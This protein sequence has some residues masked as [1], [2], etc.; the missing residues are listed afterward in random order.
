[1]IKEACVETYEE[2]LSA[3]KNGADQLEVCSHMELDGLTPDKNLIKKLIS[4]SDIPI[5]VMIR[6]RGGSFI[7][8]KHEISEMVKTIKWFK[9]LPISGFVFG[10]LKLDA[11]GNSII[12][13][14]AL[15]K[16]CNT[17]APFPVTFHKAIDLCA[18]ITEEAEK[19]KVF[20]NIRFILTSGGQST[21]EEGANTLIK[22]KH[23]VSP[24]IHII[25]AG[26]VTTQNLE[27]LRER[28][29]FEYFHGRSIV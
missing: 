5:K 6:S 29:G 23:T 11:Q 13:T 12:D 21:A 9:K 7:Y 8:S 27:G 3:I 25:A 2:S 1:M 4:T 14:H 18:N 26:K 15:K 17:A 20:S 28:L 10:A 24:N 19:L 16:I 22:M